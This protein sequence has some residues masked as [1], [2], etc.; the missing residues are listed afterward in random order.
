[1]YAGLLKKLGAANKAESTPIAQG[2]VNTRHSGFEPYLTVNILSGQLPA[3][4]A[5]AACSRAVGQ[6]I[7]IFERLD[8]M[9]SLIYCA[10]SFNPIQGANSSDRQPCYLPPKQL[11]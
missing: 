4:L 9:S 5:T 8:R 6:D 3:R 7:Q 11:K 1:M 10:T 2:L